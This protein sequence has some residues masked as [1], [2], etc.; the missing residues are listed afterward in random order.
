M[1]KVKA[2]IRDAQIDS[3]HFLDNTLWD[4]AHLSDELAR[5]TRCSKALGQAIKDV[6]SALKPGAGRL[7]MAEGHN[8]SKVERCKGV[9]IYLPLMTEISEYY[10]EV[11]FAQKHCWLTM[12]QANQAGHCE[13]DTERRI[14][15]D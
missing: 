14:T 3:A 2:K 7:I 12:L 11:D 13:L 4:I 1:P 6:R 10:P 9:T 8:G 15:N 5:R